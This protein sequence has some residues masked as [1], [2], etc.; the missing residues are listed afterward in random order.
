MAY[1][2]SSGGRWVV[3]NGRTGKRLSEHL[4]YAAAAARLEALHTKNQPL[5]RNRGREANRR[6]APCPH[7]DG[8][9]RLAGRIPHAEHDEKEGK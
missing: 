7:C 2:E 9:G 8:T 6:L 3:C 4:T 1:I 5:A